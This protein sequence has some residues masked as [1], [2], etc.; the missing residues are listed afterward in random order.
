MGNLKPTFSYAI[1]IVHQLELGVISNTLFMFKKSSI[2]KFRSNLKINF[3]VRVL[4]PINDVQEL[5]RWHAA[6]PLHA[7]ILP[8][9]L[10][11][12]KTNNVEQTD[13]QCMIACNPSALIEHFF[14]PSILCSF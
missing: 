12:I 10:N 6:F 3:K 11:S 7:H 5:L 9:R 14:I 8:L 1:S 4:L 13:I 2:G